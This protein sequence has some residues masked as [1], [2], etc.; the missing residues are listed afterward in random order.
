MSGIFERIGV[1]LPVVV[2]FCLISSCSKTKLSYKDSSHSSKT[3]N[4][5]KPYRIYLPSNYPDD[6]DKKFKVVYYLHGW[7]GTHLK[8]S[9]NLAYGSIPKLVDKYQVIM[10]FLNGR[11]ED[12][13]PR[14]YNM[15][16]HEHMLYQAQMKDYLPEV[17][18]HVDSS[19]RTMDSRYG[20]ALMG[21]SM[22]GMMAA[23][24]AGRYP[25][26]IGAAVDLCGSTEFYIGTPT[27]HTFYPLRYTFANLNDVPF[28][29]R[30]SSHGELSA[31]NWETHN[32][33]LWEGNQ[34]YDYWQ[35]NGGHEVDSKGKTEVFEKSLAF[36][37]ETLQEK[38]PP[39]KSWSHYDVYNTF[40]IWD[41]KV[42]SNKERPG[43]LFLSN[44]SKTGF[45]FHTYQWLPDGPSI[46]KIKA[47]VTTA[48]IYEPDTEYTIT[49]YDLKNKK[50]QKQNLVSDRQGRLQLE[51]DGGGHNIGIHKIGDFPKPTIVGY[52][53]EKNKKM[54]RVGERNLLSL[55]MANLGEDWK[56][57]S[58]FT[59]TLSSPDGGLEFHPSTIKGKIMN[60][61]ETNLPSVIVDC[62]KKPTDD[63]SPH[64][65]KIH[66]KME[67]ENF[68]SVN[69]F[70]MPVFFD[71]PPFDSLGID[72]GHRVKD[73]IVGAGNG[74]GIVN[75]GEEVM[76]YTNGHRTQLFYDDPYIVQEKLFDEALPAVWQT[77]GI[78]FS[79][80]IKISED[81]PKGHRLK[82]MAKYETKLYNPIKR[83]VKWGTVDL[84]VG[85][86]LP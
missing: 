8:D 77:D 18:A 37:V 15:G 34:N 42:E 3:F 12:S 16:Y 57:K 41:Y 22:G 70:Y 32:G 25:D 56:G 76:I 33:A 62:S 54:L 43:L 71:V 50:I 35:F 52:T 14:P 36:L 72:D 67:M 38:I 81:C 68:E 83:K 30:N 78:T 86:K 28:R 31:L 13:E 66:V 2:V 55:K 63:G 48:P 53:I 58:P 80:I 9:S 4:R 60:N 84:V 19:Y 20:R 82:L 44:V 75:P 59:I 51:L 6:N 85:N 40:E 17:M 79:S 10:V 69:E 46:R 24:L 61:G 27:N 29:L 45:N 23:Y 21:F 47:T 74:D 11:M 5:S 73:T 1:W 7:G 26:K 65:V 49:D 39:K 64:G